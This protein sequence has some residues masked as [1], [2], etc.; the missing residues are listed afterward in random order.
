MEQPPQQVAPSP[1]API[2]KNPAIAAVLN[3]LAPGAGYLYA[4]FYRIF[5]LDAGVFTLIFILIEWGSGWVVPWRLAQLVSILFL[6][7]GV[8]FAIDVYKRMQGRPG[9]DFIST[10]PIFVEAPPQPQYLAYATQRAEATP[11]C[12]TCGTPMTFV[13]QYNRWYCPRC[14]RYY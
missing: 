13:E 12:P 4:G 11:Q 3:F 7:A 2:T 5:G 9:F 10:E 14:R 8:I 6:I 1:P